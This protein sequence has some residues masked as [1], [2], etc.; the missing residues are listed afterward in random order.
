MPSAFAMPWRCADNLLTGAGRRSVFQEISEREP[1]RRRNCPI[2]PHG[3]TKVLPH[4][5]GCFSVT[6]SVSRACAE[7]GGK[8]L[9]VHS[10][11]AVPE[12][13]NFEDHPLPQTS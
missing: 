6:E 5:S 1:V 10:V 7:S 11:R 3:S 4:S 8:V 12:W 2:Q 9:T 13:A